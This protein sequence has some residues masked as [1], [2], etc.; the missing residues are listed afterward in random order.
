MSYV[1]LPEG[2]DFNTEFDTYV[3]ALS[4][5]TA[6][7]FVT[8]KRFFYFE[9]DK[10]FATEQEGIDF[11]KENWKIFYDIEKNIGYYKP[12]YLENSVYLENTR[13]EIR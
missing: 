5:D 9:Y 10:E 11:F 4:P 7:W 12:S 8:N 13:E 2:Y 1:E 3:I 6:S